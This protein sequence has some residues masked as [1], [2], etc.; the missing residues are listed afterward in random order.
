[1]SRLE[2]Q[3]ASKCNTQGTERQINPETWTWKTELEGPDASL[4]VN[5]GN[6]KGR[7]IGERR[8]IIQ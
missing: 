7:K 6:V 1:M 5:S 3:W 8:K 4:H 2:N